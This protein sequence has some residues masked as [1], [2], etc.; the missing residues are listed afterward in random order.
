MASN[1]TALALAGQLQRILFDQ[2]S[3]QGP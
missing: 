2:L 1:C 3:C